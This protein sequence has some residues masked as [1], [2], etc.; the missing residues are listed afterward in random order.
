MPSSNGQEEFRW[1]RGSIPVKG[2]GRKTRKSLIKRQTVLR[3]IYSTGVSWACLCC[4]DW[5]RNK[6]LVDPSEPFARGKRRDCDE[7]FSDWYWLR[8]QKSKKSSADESNGDQVRTRPMNS[9]RPWMKESFGWE[10]FFLRGSCSILR[11][12][13]FL[14]QILSTNSCSNSISS[15]FK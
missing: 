11:G 8:E 15:S 6:D 4:E 10:D 7:N 12:D 1:C 3:A 5:Q 14:L 2:G 9:K 13:F